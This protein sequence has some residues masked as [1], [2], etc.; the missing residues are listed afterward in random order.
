MKTAN[1]AY[2]IDEA[3]EWLPVTQIR[4]PSNSPRLLDAQQRHFHRRAIQQG[5]GTI[6]P[7]LV[8]RIGRRDTYELI[9]D[10]ERFL[11]AQDEGIVLV[12]CQ[13]AERCSKESMTFLMMRELLVQRSP[14]P[15]EIG[16]SIETFGQEYQ[17]RT[18]TE[19]GAIKAYVAHLADLTGCSLSLSYACQLRSAYRL[20]HDCPQEWQSWLQKLDIRL[21]LET[22]RLDPE[23]RHRLLA[24]LGLLLQQGHRLPSR[25]QVKQLV[26]TGLETDV[27]PVVLMTEFA[28]E[29]L[30]LLGC[31][32]QA[33][34]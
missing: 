18:G 15:L 34:V 7:F 12:P 16:R 4:I 22:R 24:A 8:R 26:V 6:T 27:D 17:Q 9:S 2:L 25:Q 33:A 19:R 20:V 23:R 5:G 29:L 11:A 3:C 10:C 31:R 21:L 30:A 13:V 32:T 1:L 14:S 28:P